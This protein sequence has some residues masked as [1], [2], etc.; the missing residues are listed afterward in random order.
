VHVVLRAADDI[1][2]LRRP[3]VYHAIRKALLATFTRDD[4]RVVHLS[5]QRDHV[6][7][8]GEASDRMAAHGS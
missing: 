3:Q 8:L 5:I 4:F 6:H 7:L 1:G 2:T